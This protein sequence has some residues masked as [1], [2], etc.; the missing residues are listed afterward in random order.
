M[1]GS[2]GVFW[3]LASNYADGAP[4]GTT[5][6]FLNANGVLSQVV[7][8]VEL[9]TLAEVTM[10][11]K[12]G[13]RLDQDRFLQ[14]EARVYAGDGDA[15]ELISSRRVLE[16]DVVQGAFTELTVVG[17]VTAEQSAFGTLTV[18]FEN[19]ARRLQANVDDIS[20]TIVNP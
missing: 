1:S 2:A 15:R 3:P 6:A 18:E 10:S 5:V 17:F 20:L 13:W 8:G 16:T 9:N 7:S 4:E 11:F 19:T 14:L 12:V